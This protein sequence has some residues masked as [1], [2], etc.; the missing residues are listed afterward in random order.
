VCLIG[1][2]LFPSR[3]SSGCP[4]IMF[5]IKR[6]ASVPGRIRLL[7][8]SIITMNSISMSG[9]PWGTKCSNI[10]LVFLIHPN[11]INLIHIGRVRVNV[12]NVMRASTS[13]SRS[14]IKIH[15]SFMV[16]DRLCV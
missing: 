13:Y 16:P 11:N 9:V 5:V 2:P 8:T 12:S 15:S 7:I 4:V 14:T 10:W 1:G 6:N 3:V